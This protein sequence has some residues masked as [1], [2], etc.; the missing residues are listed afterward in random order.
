MDDTMY[1]YKISLDNGDAKMYCITNAEYQAAYDLFSRWFQ[2]ERYSGKHKDLEE[3]MR[4]NGYLIGER[5]LNND[6]AT[7][8]DF[9]N[10]RFK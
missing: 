4:E 6:N 7:L 1:N 2:E 3:F 5:G 8:M 9:N 10:V